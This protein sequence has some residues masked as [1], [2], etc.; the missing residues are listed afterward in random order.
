MYS[1]L[2]KRMAITKSTLPA[3]KSTMAAAGSCRGVVCR[4]G[5]LL[6]VPT[7]RSADTVTDAVLDE[8]DVMDKAEIVE[9]NGSKELGTRRLDE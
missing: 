8:D 6:N 1:L 3:A 4:E 7:G 2:R 5:T 9:G